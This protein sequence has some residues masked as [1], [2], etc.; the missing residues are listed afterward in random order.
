MFFFFKPFVAFFSCCVSFP[1]SFLLYFLV[2][3]CYS[4]PLM[5]SM[6]WSLCSIHFVVFLCCIPFDKFVSVSVFYRMITAEEGYCLIPVIQ[7][8]LPFFS[9]WTITLAIHEQTLWP[10]LP[11]PSPRW[12]CFQFHVP[13]CS[14]LIWEDPMLKWCDSWCA[15]FDF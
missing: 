14:V 1:F 2:A 13:P 10:T 7:F 4:L 8:C 5:H 15:E 11:K 9:V 12:C 6:S 3:F